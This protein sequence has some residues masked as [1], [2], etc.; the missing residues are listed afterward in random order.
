M[1]RM[2]PRQIPKGHPSLHPKNN[3]DVCVLFPANVELHLRNACIEREPVTRMNLLTT[4]NQSAQGIIVGGLLLILLFSAGAQALAQ[5]DRM[6]DTLTNNVQVEQKLDNQ[7]DLNLEFTDEEGNQV[8]L[9]EFFEE[10][11]PVVLTLVYYGCP[12]LCGQVLNGTMR[13]LKATD[14]D[15]G[16]DY[17][18]VSISFDHTETSEMAAKKKRTFV[19]VFN[20]EGTEEGWHYLTSDSASVAAL[21]RQVGFKYFR[22]EESGQYAHSSAIM[23]LTP[24]GRVSRYFFGIEYDPQDMQ[25]GLVE[26]SNNEIGSVTDQVLL[27]CFQYNPITGTYGFAVSTALKIAG[28]ITLLLLVGFIIKS[29]RGDKKEKEEEKHSTPGMGV[30]GRA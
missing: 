27:L 20:R 17:Q 10:G 5:Q 29:V 22:D 16:E 15:I 30:P 26:A 25:L 23:V 9:G 12:M 28:S 8:R 14:L 7:I 21:A 1:K 6:M 24:E 11:K 3:S 4:R 18:V 19:H 2:K 13:S